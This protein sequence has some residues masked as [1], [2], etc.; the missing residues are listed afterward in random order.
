VQGL[1]DTLVRPDTTDAFVRQACA[2]HARIDLDV[3]PGVGHFAVR[4]AALPQ[5]L[6]WIQARLRGAPM[7]GGCTTTT[8][9][10]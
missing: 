4:T 7:D 10:L 2:A 9:G 5:S 3:Y 6:A 1:A 8:I